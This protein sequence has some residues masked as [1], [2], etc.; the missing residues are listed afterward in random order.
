MRSSRSSASAASRAN[1]STARRCS[2]RSGSCGGCEEIT[3]TPSVRPL[4]VLTGQ[5]TNEPPVYHDHACAAPA[6]SSRA[7]SA[8]AAGQSSMLRISRALPR[9]I[10]ASVTP[11]C[12]ESYGRAS[13]GVNARDAS[14]DANHEAAGRISPRSLSTTSNATPLTSIS[15]RSCSTIWSRVSLSQVSGPELMKQPGPGESPPGRLLPATRA[16]WASRRRS[17]SGAAGAEPVDREVR[18]ARLVAERLAHA[19]AH[20]VQPRRVDGG[21]APAA[22]A[23]EV[24]AC[25]S[26]REHVAARTV[27]GVHMADDAELLQALEIAI[28]RGRL[29]LRRELLRG[30][31][32]GRR[33]QRLQHRLRRHR[34][35]VAGAAQRRQY[36]VDRLELE[37]LAL[38]CERHEDN[39]TRLATAGT[40]LPWQKTDSSTATKTSP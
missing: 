33:E 25:A 8:S 7:R 18:E 40:K 23:Y 30:Q 12:S 39:P 37:R 29:Q 32:S 26:A 13:T 6:R 20:V 4:A 16:P 22:L 9:S 21:Q 27:A 5:E 1:T 3:S 14:S 38:R 28:D 17:C 24:L 11:G 36:V 34:H 31:R 2:S 35:A 10:A 15:E 19:L